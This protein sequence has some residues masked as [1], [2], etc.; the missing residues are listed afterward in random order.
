[1]PGG[2]PALDA[3][4]RDGDDGVMSTQ[5]TVATYGNVVG[6][7]V[8]PA[9]DGAEQEVIAP[10]TEQ[11]IARVPRGTQ[12]DVDRAVAAASAAARAWGRTTPAVRA[13]ALLDLA[14]RLHVLP[15]FHGNRSPR[16]DPPVRLHEVVEQPLPRGV[17][18]GGDAAGAARPAPPWAAARP[19]C[20]ASSE[21][22]DGRPPR[23]RPCG[24]PWRGGGAAGQRHAGRP[25]R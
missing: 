7:E 25:S 24:R 16:A 1:M 20:G 10:A 4:R 5:P 14:D 12:A 6:G 2:A 15:D 13:Q 18:R 21:R 19:A 8:V 22:L 23:P 3:R 9:V 17:P 11:V